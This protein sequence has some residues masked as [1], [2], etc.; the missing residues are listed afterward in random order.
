[1]SIGVY[2]DNPNV[3][4]LFRIA[5]KREYRGLHIGN[6]IVLYALSY[7]QMQGIT[8][9][10]DIISSKRNISLGLHM[11]LGF[12]PQNDWSKVTFKM[13]L[14]NVNYIQKFRLKRRLTTAYLQHKEYLS[15]KF[16]K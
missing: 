9:C 6:A 10:E 15:D 7:L 16:V 1:M 8:L 4:S 5:V 2:K 13:N 12:E 14:K 3:G 11:N